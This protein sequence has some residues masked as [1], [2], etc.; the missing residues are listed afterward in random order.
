M[1]FTSPFSRVRFLPFPSKLIALQKSYENKGITDNNWNT[2]K[3]MS[4]PVDPHGRV[5]PS[6]SLV[7]VSRK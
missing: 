6:G 7:S 2:L 1:C 4:C 3:Y 5:A